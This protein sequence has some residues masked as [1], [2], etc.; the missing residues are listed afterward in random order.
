MK[1]Q[2][3]DSILDTAAR[4]M[5]R[6]GRD[7]HLSPKAFELL[8]LL[9]ERRPAALS[10]AEIHEFIWPATFVSDDSVAKLITEIRHGIGDDSREPRFVRTVHGFGYAFT[11]A[12]EAIRDTESSEAPDLRCWLRWEGRELLI[13]K[14]RIVIGRDPGVD[15]Q[16]E[17]PRISRQHAQIV[18]EGDKAFI[19]DLG[20]KNGTFLHEQRVI[21][22]TP[23]AHGDEIRIGPFVLTFRSSSPSSIT[24]TEVESI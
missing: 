21:G 20:S 2:F 23:L 15:V 5:V 1:L 24:E 22:P 12:V 11:D 10:K 7:V 6:G 18:I 8:C 3:G 16:L 13:Q 4:Q 9:V 17:S 19:E 14:R